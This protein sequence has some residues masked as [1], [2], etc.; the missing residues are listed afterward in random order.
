METEN[1]CVDELD[2]ASP[3]GMHRRKIKI[4]KARTYNLQII[5][6]IDYIKLVLLQEDQ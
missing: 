5:K 6:V 1:V 2:T 3:S 4:I